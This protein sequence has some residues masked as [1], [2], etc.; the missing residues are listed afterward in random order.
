[1]TNVDGAGDE[2][3]DLVADYGAQRW[4]FQCKWRQRA[5]VGDSAI[6][7]VQN[8]MRKYQASRAAVV[9]NSTFTR[10]AHEHVQTIA[11]LTEIKIG[12]W[13]GADLEALWADKKNCSE[14]LP[15]PELRPYQADAFAAVQYDLQARSRSFLVLATG[16]GKTV[17]AGT[18]IQ[19]F[20]QANP[21]A[22]ILVVAHARDLVD[23]LQR[24]LWRHV[25]KT[26]PVQ[27]FTGDDKPTLLDGV[28]CATVQAVITHIRMGWRPDFIFIDEAHHVGDDGLYAE[29]LDLCS[30]AKILGVTATPWRGDSVD[31]LKHFGGASFKLG[32]EEGMRF[33]YLCDVRYKVFVDDID[34]DLVRSISAH[35]YS[36]GDL[37]S[38]LFIPQRDEK[39][40]DEL[41]S[42][43]N[44]TRSPRAIVFC[45]TI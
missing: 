24:A 27:Q 4:V 26:V 40:R 25:P 28:T 20:M 1:M 18:V 39:I 14:D 13:S 29:M 9:T 11:Q 15:Q 30:G 6:F 31:V 16:L 5:A 7:E 12:L 23:Q 43:W 37:N 17:I 34:W 32:I 21:G 10:S 36:I 44:Q 19:A 35:N 38:K 41:L 8:A 42:A 3:A 45:Q 2:G 33:G 22:T